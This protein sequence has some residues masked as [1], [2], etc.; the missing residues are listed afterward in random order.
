MNRA[1]IVRPDML[2]KRIQ[3]IA[4]RP[5][6]VEM[7]QGQRGAMIGDFN[8]T[9]KLIYKGDAIDWHR[10]LAYGW[11]LTPDENVL[12]PV[13]SRHLTPTQVNAL[14][15]WVSKR[16]DGKF[17]VR[18]RFSDEVFWVLA[19][20]I[21]HYAAV[22]KAYGIPPRFGD[23]IDLWVARYEKRIIPG[24]SHISKYARSVE[25]HFEENRDADEWKI[26]V[27]GG[28]FTSSETISQPDEKATVFERNE[29]SS[30]FDR[31]DDE[32]NWME[33]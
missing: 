19:L 23:Q 27:A 14:S 31:G 30:I 28:R 8:R 9:L 4:L 16:D 32:I 11:M 13:S 5:T 25:K 22:Q 6:P 18:T 3:K 1:E 12:Y 21:Q 10:R 2:R 33:V 26:R 24:E 20:A 15:M 7:N 17:V 29:M